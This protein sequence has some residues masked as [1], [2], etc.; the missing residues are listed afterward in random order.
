M[1]A[2]VPA[3]SQHPPRLAERLLLRVQREVVEHEGRE[4][5]VERRLRVRQLVRDTAIE[6]HRQASLLRFLPCALER[7]G[8]G[9]E[10]HDLGSRMETLDKERQVPRPA[11]D[12]QDVMSRL[13]VRLSDELPVS[14]VSLYQLGEEVVQGQPVVAR[15]RKKG[16]LSFACSSAHGHFLASITTFWRHERSFT[17]RR[18]ALAIHDSRPLAA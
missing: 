13:D 1:G 11:A 15:R 4:H 8:V 12:V 3:A 10:A 16:P 2:L 14:R 7:L 5:A 9:I 17:Y 6:S 18:L